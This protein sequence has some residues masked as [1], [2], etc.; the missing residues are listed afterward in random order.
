MWKR[1]NTAKSSNGTTARQSAI[2]EPVLV[3][4]TVFEK[5]YGGA[6]GINVNMDRSF[7]P[8][9]RSTRDKPPK[10]LPLLPL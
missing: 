3:E 7:V 10:G 5:F 1:L 8:P 9:S 4:T 2:S 6:G